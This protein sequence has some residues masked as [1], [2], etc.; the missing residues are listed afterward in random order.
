MQPLY[1]MVN[2]KFAIAMAAMHRKRITYRSARRMAYEAMRAACA[3]VRRAGAK[4]IT[5]V[6]DLTARSFGPWVDG[7][8]VGLV[9]AATL[10]S[11]SI[12]GGEMAQMS[13]YER[14]AASVVVTC[15]G[16]K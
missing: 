12:V 1:P 13:N 3:K 9:E 5:T 8:A 7:F 10:E 14:G 6:D 11:V 15:V 4:P 2:P 16:L